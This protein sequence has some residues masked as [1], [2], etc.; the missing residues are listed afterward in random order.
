MKKTPSLVFVAK[1]LVVALGALSPFAAFAD[2]PPAP[3]PPEP[4]APIPVPVPPAPG[5]VP[6]PTTQPTPQGK[7]QYAL[8]IDDDMSALLLNSVNFQSTTPVNINNSTGTCTA[9]QKSWGSGSQALVC[10]TTSSCTSTVPACV[11]TLQAPA[12]MSGSDFV[13]VLNSAAATSGSD[14]PNS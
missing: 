3:R 14:G 11:M 10:R 7:Q 2:I 12:G 9:Q 6:V 1:W 8:Q 5:P 4:P 13:S